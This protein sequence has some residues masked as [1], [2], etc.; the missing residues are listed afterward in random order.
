MPEICNL[1]TESLRASNRHP[2]FYSKTPRAPRDDA[3]LA[4]SKIRQNATQSDRM[5][6]DATKLVPARTRARQRNSVP[7]LSAWIAPRSQRILGVA[8]PEPSSQ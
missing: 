7:L 8:V 2:S 1:P 5:P 6:H 3:K 4:V